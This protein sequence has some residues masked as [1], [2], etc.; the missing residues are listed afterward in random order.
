MAKKEKTV[1]LKPRAEKIS[2][3]HLEALQKLVN[4]I[5]SIQF[6]VGKLEVQKFGLMNQLGNAQTRISTFQRVLTE[7]YGT[8]DVNIEDGTINWSEEDKEKEEDEK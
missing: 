7:K 5:N 8:F 4:N 6:N 3:E 2:Q 1:D